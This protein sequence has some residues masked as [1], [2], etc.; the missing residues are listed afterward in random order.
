MKYRDISFF[1]RISFHITV[2]IAYFCVI[3]T[4]VGCSDLIVYLILVTC[5]YLETS[6]TELTVPSVLT[7]L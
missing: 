1:Q 7:A 2:K 6:V 3:L 5:N 4:A